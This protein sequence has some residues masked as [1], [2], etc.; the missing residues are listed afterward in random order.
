MEFNFGNI[1]KDIKRSIK[2]SN[3]FPLLVI[4]TCGFVLFSPKKINELFY[5]HYIKDEYKWIFGLLFLI[6]VAIILLKIIQ[7]IY[8]YL[9]RLLKKISKVVG[10]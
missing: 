6:A 7:G 9:Y 4:I 5:L 3:F 2:I 1:F 10:K 8:Y